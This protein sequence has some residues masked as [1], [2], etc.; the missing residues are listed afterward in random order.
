MHRKQ[1]PQRRPL[2]KVSI[3]RECPCGGAGA[4]EGADGEAWLPEL[5]PCQGGGDNADT[6]GAI[7]GTGEADA[8][9]LSSVAP[10]LPPVT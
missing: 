1:K 10:S 6:H 2:S 3:R 5:V 8:D 7:L 4:V 9:T